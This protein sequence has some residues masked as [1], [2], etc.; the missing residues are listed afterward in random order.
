MDFFSAPL[1]FNKIIFQDKFYYP[2]Q[3]N[4]LIDQ[5]TLYLKS[6]KQSNSPFIHLFAHNHVKTIVAYFAIIKANKIC[7]LVDPDIKHIELGE[8]M[9]DTPPYAMIKLN[10]LTEEFDY[11][12]EIEFK[13]NNIDVDTRQLEDVCMMV[14][15]NAEDGFSKAVMLTRNN[16]LSDGQSG[17]SIENITR[18]KVVAPFLPLSHSFGIFAGLIGPILGGST[19]LIVDITD[20]KKIRTYINYIK[21]Y[22]VTNIYSIPLTYLLLS[23]IPNIKNIV[24]SVNKFCSGGYKL[25]NTIRDKFQSTVG[26]ILFE[27]YGLTEASPVCSS[28]RTGDTLKISSVGR[29]YLCCQIKIMDEDNIELPI[30]QEGEICVKGDN[31][32]KGYYNNPVAT[33]KTLKHGWLHTGDWGRMDKDGFLYFTGLKKNMLN[34][35][36]KKAYPL[37]V[38]RLIRMNKNIK[39]VKIYGEFSEL[40][41]HILKAEI[42]F[43]NENDNQEEELKKWCKKNI[44][45]HKIPQF[46]NINTK[47]LYCKSITRQR[48]VNV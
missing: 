27:G 46:T 13:D 45:N 22:N 30:G 14:Y 47:L 6:N 43:N 17:V 26:N 15:T 12:N 31:I 36:G 42:E 29:E 44:S 48:E 20:F 24:Q 16:I 35:Y 41:G 9:Q 33:K 37:E 39:S 10:K 2:P 11:N 4:H 5:L 38:E 23:K 34:I 7:V 40:Y 32:M 19:L 3:I 21:C 28:Y 1:Q 8:M 18:D 25:S